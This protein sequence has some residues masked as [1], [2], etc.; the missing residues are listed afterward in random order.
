MNGLLARLQAALARERR[1]VADAAHEL[2]TPLAVLRTELE[3]ASRRERTR[4]ELVD[5]VAN[6]ARE[7]DRLV[8]LTEDL[9][10]LART[11]EGVPVLRSE[12][13]HLGDFLNTALSAH[14]QRAAA[15]GVSCH[16]NVVDDAV[17]M[18]DEARV[19]QAVE[20][21]LDNALR[22]APPGSSIEVDARVEDG[23]AVIAISDDGPGFP[24]DL[25]PEAFQRFRRGD[26]ARAR[27][28]GGSGLG[29]AIVQ[30]IARAHGGWADAAN[31][32][33][34]G[35]T[36]RLAIPVH[37]SAAHCLEAVTQ[38]LISPERSPVQV[39]HGSWNRSP[40]RAWRKAA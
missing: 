26:V 1:L 37:G 8:R 40:S 11:D 6:A 3:L 27:Q 17:V 38:V 29:L 23:M 9:L 5:A 10:F 24:P 28:D 12:P 15:G 14:A 32:P 19:R 7:T 30:A 20:N 36:V 31:R 25:L 18:L 34:G 16:V 22:V 39:A 21:L 33:D 2:R 13:Q 35:A 4:E